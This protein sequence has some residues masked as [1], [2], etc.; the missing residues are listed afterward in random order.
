MFAQAISTT[1]R[2]IDLVSS[3]YCILALRQGLEVNWWSPLFAVAV[4]AARRASLTQ[5]IANKYLRNVA[6]A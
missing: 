2:M 1:V 5:Q 3:I 6:Y 4:V